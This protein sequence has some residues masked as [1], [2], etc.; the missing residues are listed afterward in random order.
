[1]TSCELTSG[2]DFWSRGHLGMAVM[3]LAIKFDADTFILFR[4]IDIF[5]LCEFGHSGVLTVW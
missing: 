5:I 4:V 1:M 3:H 2:V